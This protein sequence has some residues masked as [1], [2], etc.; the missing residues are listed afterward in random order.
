M[1]VS[2]TARVVIGTAVSYREIIAQWCT[3]VPNYTRYHPCK[4]QAGLRCCGS[5]LV[6]KS[7]GRVFEMLLSECVD[8]T[9]VEDEAT[10]EHGS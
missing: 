8:F 10:D 4:P 3:Y 5:N 6:G 2:P 1:L 9:E 7:E